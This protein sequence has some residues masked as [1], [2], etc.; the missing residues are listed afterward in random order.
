MTDSSM[1]A[2]SVVVVTW[3]PELLAPVTGAFTSGGEGVPELLAPAMGASTSGRE[4]VPEV[5]APP[6][7]AFTSGRGEE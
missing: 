6:T 1:G 7:G 2:S 5:L 4:K 3:V